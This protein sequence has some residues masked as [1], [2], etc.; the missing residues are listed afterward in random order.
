[1]KRCGLFAGFTTLA[2]LLWLV[3]S[4]RQ[5]P[6]TNHQSRKQPYLAACMPEDDRLILAVSA[7]AHEGEERGKGLG[8]V[9]MVDE[10]RLRARGEGLRFPRRGRRDAIAVTNEAV[11]DGDVHAARQRVAI[12]AQHRAETRDDATHLRFDGGRWI[13]GTDP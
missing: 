7:I 6:V 13:V 2:G 10:Q 9:G 8:R 4:S 12:R 1:M 11:I 5:P 3:E